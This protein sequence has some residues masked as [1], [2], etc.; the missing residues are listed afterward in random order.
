[1]AGRSLS[2][3]FPF[4][5]V[6]VVC[7]TGVEVM[8]LGLERYLREPATTSRPAQSSETVVSE[9][10]ED[11]PT[12]SKEIDYTIITKRNLFGPAAAD[13][14]TPEI[15]AAASPE[16]ELEATK[17]EIV[18]MGTVGA[19]EDG[20]RAIIMQKK[21][22]TQALYRAGDTI[23]GAVIKDI[24]RGRVIL[25]VG[26]Q[27]EM[28]DIA[29]A[30]EYAAGGPG[31][32]GSS[33]PFRRRSVIVAPQ[34]ASGQQVQEPPR[35]VQPLRRIVRPPVANQT[36]APQSGGEEVE[37]APPDQE[38]GPEEAVQEAPAVEEQIEPTGD[39]AAAQ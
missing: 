32:V 20:A 18:L 36:E 16:E 14:T 8:Y 21:D 23:E 7:V 24:R 4:L 33:P 35:V 29:E 13:D 39:G 10:P 31:P 27:D 30:R 12:A 17:L 19:D 1:M 9:K 5:V 34:Q 38:T 28:L 25:T 26:G 15:E 3:F 2:N 22:R 6:T 37:Q 11:G